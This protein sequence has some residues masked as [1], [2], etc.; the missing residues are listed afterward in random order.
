[1]V[2]AAQVDPLQSSCPDDRVCART[3]SAPYLVCVASSG[4]ND[5]GADGGACPTE[6][7]VRHD[8]AGTVADARTCVGACRCSPDRLLPALTES[9]RRQGTLFAGRPAIREGRDQLSTN[10]ASI[11]VR[12]EAR[13]R[14]RR[15][16]AREEV[17]YRLFGRTCVRGGGQVVGRRL[18]AP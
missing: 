3:V 2:C 1:R 4:Q 9:S 8:L 12:L 7:P 17:E 10:V 6:Y 11:E 16:C 15:Q 14:V 5:G 18:E 13:D